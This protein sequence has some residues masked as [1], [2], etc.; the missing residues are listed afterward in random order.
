[1]AKRKIVAGDCETWPFKFGR[2]PKA[3][4][5]C[6]FDGD[7]YHL[8]DTCDEMVEFLHDK[9][10]IVYFHNG[11]KYDYHFMLEHLEEFTP[12]MNINGRLAKFTIGE[13]EFRDSYN[14]IPQP[15][16]AYKKDD[17]D[18]SKLEPDVYKK[19]MREIKK[20][21]M[22]DCLFL[23]EMVT[24]FIDE[25]GVNLTLASA[26]FKYFNDNFNEKGN[27]KTDSLFYDE[28]K[29]FY[30]GGRVECFTKGKINH[31]LK[32][33]DINSAYP[34]AMLHDHPYGNVID[35]Y[36]ELPEKDV[37][38]CFIDLECVADGCFPFRGED[39]SL[40]F[41]SDNEKRRYFVTG[42]E[43]EAAIDHDAIKDVKINK[44]YK[45]LERIN[46][47][48][49]VHH[50]YD[51]KNKAEK[52]TA[53]YIIAK[54]YLNSLY[55]KYAANPEKYC[56]TFICPPEY[57]EHTCEMLDLEYAGDLG[58]WAVLERPLPE[59][60]QNYYN[61]ATAA[62]ITGFVRAY[63]FQAM[64]Q[65][66]N[67]VYCDTDSLFCESADLRLSDKLGDWDLE[68]EFSHGGIAGKKLYAFK[69]K[70]KDDYKMASKGARLT[71]EEVLKVCSG[72]KITYKSIAP[73]FSLKRDTFFLE[74][75]IKMT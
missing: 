1:M 68:G 10:W 55:G 20:Y 26:A 59:E 14:I 38:R 22:N 67:V 70:D 40:S 5:W 57:I 45:F 64:R 11:G 33:Y 63:L 2:I 3:L 18:Y 65:C 73:T 54:L 9:K 56:E 69:Y 7:E 29:K 42:W 46:F 36:N 31:E 32:C 39:K 19:H 75:E 25:Y 53:H 23:Y 17:F 44:V 43:Y 21:L 4:I 24:A 15:L 72:E 61:V 13:C 49:Y 35:E 12:I 34:F 50:F 51:L 66:K 48:P 8:F 27:Q 52:G 6:I 16:A 37:E 62:S 47:S 58:K 41:P 30:Y 71:A 74:R 60:K 28:F